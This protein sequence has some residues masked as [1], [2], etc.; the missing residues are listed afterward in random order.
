MT[1]T[2]T[3]AGYEERVRE[4]FSRL[5]FMR[6]IGARLLTVTPGEVEI[7]MPVRDDLTQQ[8]GYVSGAAIQGLDEVPAPSSSGISS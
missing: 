5:A 1:F 6:T 8:H 3:D 4:S 7:D 2:P